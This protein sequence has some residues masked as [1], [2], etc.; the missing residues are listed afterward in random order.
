MQEIKSTKN[1]G[2]N[3]MFT[4]VCSIIDNKNYVPEETA[5]KIKEVVLEAQ[6]IREESWNKKKEV[7]EISLSKATSMAMKKFDLDEFWRSIICEFNE[8]YWNDVQ[9]WAK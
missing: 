3:D 8:F 9:Y 4:S 7:Y 5:K 1:N 2:E 6:K